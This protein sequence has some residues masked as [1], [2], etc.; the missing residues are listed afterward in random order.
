[1][2]DGGIRGNQK[3]FF[4]RAGGQRKFHAVISG[5]RNRRLEAERNES[6]RRLDCTILFHKDF[7]SASESRKQPF[8]SCW[9]LVI[10]SDAHQ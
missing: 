9:I 3:L 7:T 4:L 5:V 8:S 6:L 1:M 10:I 2:Q